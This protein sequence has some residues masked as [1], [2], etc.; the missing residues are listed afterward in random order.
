MLIIFGRWLVL[1]ILARKEYKMTLKQKIEQRI[2]ASKADF[3]TGLKAEIEEYEKANEAVDRLMNWLL[4]YYRKYVSNMLGEVISERIL[5]GLKTR[6][7]NKHYI[8]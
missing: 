3:I 6:N 4:Y 1:L 2:E 7:K 5:E 8:N